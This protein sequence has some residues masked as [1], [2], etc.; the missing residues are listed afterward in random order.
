[1]LLLIS[2][3][4]PTNRKIYRG[5]G[6]I[7]L[8]VFLFYPWSFTAVPEMRVLILDENGNVAPDAV[9]QEKWEYKRIGSREHREVFRAD[10]DGYAT[11]PKRT[12]RIPLIILLPSIAREI[13]HLPHGYGYGS[14]FTIFAYG[15]DQFVWEYIPLSSYET[16]PRELRL[17]RQDEIRFPDDGKWP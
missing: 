10:R 16:V 2:T 3:S 14:V 11:F 4:M 7:F 1:V 17:K 9:V 15:K 12:E 6:V 5:L 13:V 8:L